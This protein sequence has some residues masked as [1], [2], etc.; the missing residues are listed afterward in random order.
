M[1][2]YNYILFLNLFVLSL[3]VLHENISIESIHCIFS[4]WLEVNPI[5]FTSLVN[6][7]RFSTQNLCFYFN[8]H[9]SPFKNYLWL[10]FRLINLIN[11][12]Q[13]CLFSEGV[14]FIFKM[15][16]IQ[17]ILKIFKFKIFVLLTILFFLILYSLLTLPSFFKQ[18][19]IFH[20][21]PINLVKISPPNSFFIN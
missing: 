21:N 14:Y 20:I 11:L 13:H 17:A 12:Y 19:H 1:L 7:L 16:Y 8:I 4:S 10:S 9:L 2:L 18:L 15:I 6:T 3:L 5:L